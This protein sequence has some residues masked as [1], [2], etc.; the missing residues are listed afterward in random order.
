MAKN[1]PC[2][3]GDKDLIAGWETMSPHVTEQLSSGTA[4]TESRMLQNL[5]ATIGES[6]CLNKRSHVTQQRFHVQQLISSVAK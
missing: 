3:A 2:N 4:T 6:V 5:C 1:L